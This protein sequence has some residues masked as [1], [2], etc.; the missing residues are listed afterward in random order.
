[1]RNNSALK[2]LRKQQRIKQAYRHV[3][4]ET[5]EDGRI[6]LEHLSR[7]AGLTRPKLSMNDIQLRENVGER[8]IVWSIIKYLKTSDAQLFKNMERQA[9]YESQNLERQNENLPNTNS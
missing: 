3:F 2:W 8:R 1:M 5:G 9:L 6:V 7:Q 4:E